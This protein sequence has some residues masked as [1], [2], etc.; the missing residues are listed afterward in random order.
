MKI[1][2]EKRVVSEKCVGMISVFLH[3]LSLRS[4]F[5]VQG[6]ALALQNRCAILL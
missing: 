4:D 5:G 3:N 6:Q 1:M 2:S